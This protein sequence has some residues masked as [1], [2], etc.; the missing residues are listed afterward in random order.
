M[1][2]AVERHPELI[3]GSKKRLCTDIAR[4]TGGRFSHNLRPPRRR[5]SR[6][7][8]GRRDLSATYAAAWRK[9][10]ICYMGNVARMAILD[11]N[12]WLYD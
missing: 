9:R 11:S 10:R 4:A 1:L 7:L 3:A 5:R 2:R 12:N 8:L 6:V